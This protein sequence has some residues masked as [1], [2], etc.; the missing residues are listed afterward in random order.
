MVEV[1]G[2]AA[3]TSVGQALLA[4]LLVTPSVIPWDISLGIDPTGLEESQTAVL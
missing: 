2:M 4:I 3:A 1:P